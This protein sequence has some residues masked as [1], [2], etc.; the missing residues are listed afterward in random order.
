MKESGLSLKEKNLHNI[1]F[2]I[3][4]LPKSTKNLL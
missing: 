1:G 3:Y 2:P 4:K